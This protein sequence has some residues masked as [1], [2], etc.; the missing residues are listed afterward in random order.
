MSS[1]KTDNAYTLLSGETLSYERP[2]ARASEFL[3]RVVKAA[4]A[5]DV[6]ESEFLGL[7]L[8]AENPVL[9]TTANGGVPLRSFGDPVFQI[10]VDLLCRKRLQ[11]TQRRDTERNYTMTVQQAGAARQVHESAIRQAIQTQRLHAVKRGRAWLVDPR[12]VSALELNPKKAPNATASANKPLPAIEAHVGSGVDGS[13]RLKAVEFVK[14]AGGSGKVLGFVPTF[15]KAAVIFGPKGKY[16]MF[17]LEHA[18]GERGEVRFE[19]FYARGAFRVAEKINNAQAAS[20][21]W[22]EF[23]AE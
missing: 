21:R 14:Q 23:E 18:P 12:D 9:G 13:F 19:P 8:S 2:S 1:T 20:E 11:M 5:P 7:I 6:G 15:E 4:H 22:R 3:Q 16:R 10:M 17:V